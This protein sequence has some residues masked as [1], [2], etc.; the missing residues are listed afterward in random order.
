MSRSL[1]PDGERYDTCDGCGVPDDISIIR[2]PTGE[3]RGYL[4]S[5]CACCGHEDEMRIYGGPGT[6]IKK[7]RPKWA[8]SQGV[9]TE[10]HT[11]TLATRGKALLCDFCAGDEARSFRAYQEDL[12]AAGQYAPTRYAEIVTLAYTGMRIGELYGLEW[13]DVDLAGRTLKIRRAVWRKQVASTKTD[14][15][16]EVPL[17]SI[18]VDVLKT[19]RAQQVAEQHPGLAAGIVFPSDA[20]E[21]RYGSS[22]R[23]PMA[24]LQE[25]LGFEVRITPQ[26]L[27]RTFNTLMLEAHVDRIVLRSIMG[28]SDESMTQRYAGVR[29]DLKLQAIDRVFG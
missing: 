8:S 16:R 24:L 29:P 13:Q 28:H 3:W 25:H 19:H 10:W 1:L 9:D 15:P 7:G 27:R 17:P 14:A 22:L 11:A 2:R 4:Y 18:V 6:S 26:V 23:K 20:G 12:E 21:R 5:E